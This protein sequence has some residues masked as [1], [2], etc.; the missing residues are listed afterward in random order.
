MARAELRV[1][2]VLSPTTELVLSTEL[3]YHPVS[4]RFERLR[5]LALDA[6]PDLRAKR[7]AQSQRMAELKLAKAYRYPDVTIGGGYAV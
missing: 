4:P 5:L 7:L 2:L 6:R 1:L 3:E